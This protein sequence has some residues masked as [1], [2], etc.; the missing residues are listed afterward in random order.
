VDTNGVEHEATSAQGSPIETVFL[1]TYTF[2]GVPLAKAKEFQVQVR[3]V[4][5]IEFPNVALKP[6]GHVSRQ[7]K[8]AFGPVVERS[9]DETIDFDSVTTAGLIGTVADNS[10][11]SGIGENDRSM[12]TNDNDAVVGIGELRPI[13]MDFVLL[14]DSDWDTLKPA[15][16]QDMVYRNFYH[17]SSVKREEGSSTFGFRT[18]EHGVGMLQLVS[19]EEGKP[20]VTLRYKMVRRA[21]SK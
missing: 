19:F 21:S 6:S 12:A 7:T 13:D 17:P 5:W 1:W 16:L 15:E 18:R 8:P 10:P 4:H 3:P 20:G 14:K 11:I 2:E 9:F